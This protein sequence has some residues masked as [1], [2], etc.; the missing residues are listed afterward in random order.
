MGEVR[1]LLPHTDKR[2][3]GYRVYPETNP[4]NFND[5]MIKSGMEAI[6]L[7]LLCSAGILIG[8]LAVFAIWG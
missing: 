1:N 5:L 2:P 6:K 4:P 3:A 7:A 8:A